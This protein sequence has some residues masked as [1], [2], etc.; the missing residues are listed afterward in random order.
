M[1]ASD[2]SAE[3]AWTAFLPLI[4]TQLFK[5]VRS[6]RLSKTPLAFC[7]R[8]Q[9]RHWTSLESYIIQANSSCRRSAC[10]ASLS[11]PRR[12]HHIF[13]HFDREL[14]TDERSP[15]CPPRHLPQLHIPLS[16]QIMLPSLPLS[17]TSHPHSMPAHPAPFPIVSS[18]PPTS[19]IP[20]APPRDPKPLIHLQM[21]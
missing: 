20:V 10:L 17:L 13:D 21:L 9:F 14:S 19:S 6:A 5:T 16:H 7:V 2:F 4:T 12:S 11:R 8:T 1:L 18:P 15:T 3:I